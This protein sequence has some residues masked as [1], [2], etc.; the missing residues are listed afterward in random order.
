MP[1]CCGTCGSSSLLDGRGLPEAEDPDSRD[2]DDDAFLAFVLGPAD[3]TGMREFRNFR[4]EVLGD[5]DDE[6]F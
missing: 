3:F 4:R 2:L 6:P 1:F 5:T